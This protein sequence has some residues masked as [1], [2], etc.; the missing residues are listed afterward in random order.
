MLTNSANT[1]SAASAF[2]NSMLSVSNF[3]TTFDFNLSNPGFM[4]DG[5]TFTVQRQGANALGFSGGDLG[6]AGIGQS[7]AIKFDTFQNGGDP[8]S[9]S[10]GVFTNGAS[11]LGGVDTSPVNLNSGDNMQATIDYNQA[12]AAN[13]LH[14]H[15]ADFTASS[16]F[17]V[18][19]EINIP[20]TI[21]GNSAFVGFT[22][23]TGSATSTQQILDWKFQST[24]EAGSLAMLL[25]GLAGCGVF[26]WR[27]KRSQ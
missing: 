22:G 9:S 14:V 2:S 18:F 5:I 13:N 16:F 25:P 27:R 11:P 4:G 24:P 8:S 19:F 3:H 23:G 15:L 7:V 21:G 20:S 26:M 12:L 1:G 10:V 6:Y 17:D